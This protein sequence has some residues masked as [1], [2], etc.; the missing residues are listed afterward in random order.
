MSEAIKKSAVEQVESWPV[1]L[2]RPYENNVKIHTEEQIKEIAASIKRFGPDQ[3]I[4]VDGAGVIIKGHG[5]LM[6]A[7]HLGMKVFPVIVRKDL[8]AAEAAAS[9]IVDNRVARTDDDANKLKA[10]IDSLVTAGE[11]EVPDLMELGFDQKE[12]NFSLKDLADLDFGQTM[13]L[14]EAAESQISKTE[15]LLSDLKG[16]EA[17]IHNVFGFKFVPG[18]YAA[19]ISEFLTLIAAQEGGEVTPA[20]ALGRYCER[21]VQANSR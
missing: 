20:E 6:A 9:R 19:A 14:E 11:F 13:D 10:E 3:P 18:Q 1:E 2:I 15:K 16:R 12:L 17:N 7:K 21:Y 8:T 4:V 5:R